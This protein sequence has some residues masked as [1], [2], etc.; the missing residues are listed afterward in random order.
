MKGWVAIKKWVLLIIYLSFIPVFILGMV[1]GAG[2]VKDGGKIELREEIK[3]AILSGK[4]QKV[5]VFFIAQDA[6]SKKT[7]PATYI[8]L[9]DTSP[10]TP[11]ASQSLTIAGS[12]DEGYRQVKE[13]K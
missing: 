1:A 12:G 4:A 11:Y 8:W 10:L 6:K 7:N 13:G 3:K 5:D 2:I 9:S